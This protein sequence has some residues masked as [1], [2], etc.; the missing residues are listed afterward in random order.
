[1]FEQSFMELYWQ[2]NEMQLQNYVSDSCNDL[3]VIDRKIYELLSKSDISCYPFLLRT[4]VDTSPDCSF[5][6]NK[7]DNFKD[8]E[9]NI[10]DDDKKDTNQYKLKLAKAK[11][12]DVIALMRVRGERAKALDFR[13]YPE[14]VLSLDGL[15]KAKLR[16]ILKKHLDE[17]RD[18]VRSLI[19]QYQIK[20]PTWFSDLDNICDSKNNYSSDEQVQYLLSKLGLNLKGNLK[21]KVSSDNFASFVIP[22][23]K[24][25]IN[26]I[27]KESN[28]SSEVLT[29]F[30]ELG[31]AIHYSMIEGSGLSNVL[32]PSISEIMAVVMEYIATQILFE[33]DERKKLNDIML[34][35]YTRCAISSLFELELWENIAGAEELYMKH[36][37]Q[38][39]IEISNPSVWS[40]DSFRSIDVVYIHNYVLGYIIAKEL[41]KKFTDAYGDNF[42]RWGNWLVEN[43]YKHGS[44]LVLQDVMKIYI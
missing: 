23:S 44:N 5:L 29:L 39:G 25:N 10:S 30:H 9:K 42:S 27:I 4:I 3:T 28:S 8:Y 20:W 43:I 7:I 32:P 12:E 15:T 13:S 41:Y 36:Y 35:D 37:S 21:F 2:R 26:V 31:H 11:K 14:L 34:I 1:M 22:T 24:E 33:G 40:S 6:V 19:E 18:S 16:S 38:L 17:N